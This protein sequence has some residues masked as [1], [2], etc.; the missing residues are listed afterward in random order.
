AAAARRHSPVTVHALPATISALQQHVFN[1]VIWPDFTVLPSAEQ[2]FMVFQPFEVGQQ[3]PLGGLHVEV[4]PAAH[5]V[6]AVGFALARH[7]N[8]APH[9]VFS[10]D[11]GYNPSFWHRI[12]QLHVG[13][14]VIETAFSNR[15]APLAAVSQ[16]LCPQSLAQCLALISP[17]AA[18]P[19]F[20]T[21]AKP[22]EASLVMAEIGQFNAA[23]H[24][25]SLV[26]LTIDGLVGGQ[27]LNV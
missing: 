3:L 6:P 13:M 10:G 15:E 23:R 11:T 9:W 17:H 26:P 5:T 14:L 21:H 22:A 25:A 19:V 12:N 27:I 24:A 20:I 16:H 2:P 1:G 7:A 4:L 18:Y 8:G